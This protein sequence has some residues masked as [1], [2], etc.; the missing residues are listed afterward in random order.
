MVGLRKEFSGFVAVH[1][2][3][4]DIREGEF[5]TL[6]GPS[7]CGK[8]TLLRMIAGFE[9]PTSGR[10]LFEGNDIAPVPPELRPFNMVFQSYAL[11][12]HMSVFDNVAYGLRTA[13]LA[14]SHVRAQ[15]ID[16]LDLVG[17]ADRTDVSVQALSGGQQQRVALV[18]ALVNEPRV[19]LL[20][21]PLGALDLKL[22]KRMQ[23][24]LRSIQQRVN[25]T[26]VY[27]T[28]D[29]EEALVMSH[30]IVLIRDGRIA[31]VGTPDEVYHRPESRFVAE[32]VGDANMLA[33]AVI[34][35]EGRDVRVKL[36][37]A[38]HEA[39][40]PHYG[41]DRLDAGESGLVAVRPEHMHLAPPE[42]S[43]I[44]GTLRA[45]VLLGPVTVHEVAIRDGPTIRVQAS[46]SDDAHPGDRVG[47]E[48]YPRRGTVVR[49]EESTIG[50]G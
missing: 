25:T 34:G 6:L 50:T 17:L 43:D 22:R 11:F 32:F 20:D 42:G 19:L 23:D 18:R 2:F 40:F 13:R 12:P 41:Q 9:R 1:D 14:E 39:M 27:V 30:R 8:T 4:L 35:R 48:I 28:H 5:I 33:C 7:G 26:F 45:S 29:Q 24:E 16:A 38:G 10:L 44:V 37:D 36:E 49:R 3:D 47:V 15:V 46:P 31:Q 21:E